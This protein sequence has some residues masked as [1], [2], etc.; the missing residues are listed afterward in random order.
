MK[1]ICIPQCICMDCKHYCYKKGKCKLQETINLP[2][3]Q[4]C[5]INKYKRNVWKYI[6]RKLLNVAIA[7]TS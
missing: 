7:I 6:G 1:D 4:N 2:R 3:L 5:P